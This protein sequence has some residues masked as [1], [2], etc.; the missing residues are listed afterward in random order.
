MSTTHKIF[1]D[2]INI[3]EL[4]MNKYL[5]VFRCGERLYKFVG[6]SYGMPEHIP[7]SLR[8]G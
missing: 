4:Y 3:E 1:R 8:K 6:N 5:L 7:P 2:F